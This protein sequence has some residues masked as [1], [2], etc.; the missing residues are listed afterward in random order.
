[1][2][3]VVLFGPPAVGKMTVGREL[4]RL[5]PYRLFHNHATIEPLLDVFAWGEPAF[6]LLREEFRRRI[7]EEAVATDLPGLVFTLVWGLEVA[8]D[9][10]YVE[11]LVEPVVAAGGRVDFAE[12]WSTQETRLAREGTPLRLE[13]KRS[14]RDVAWARAH[15]VESDA[16]HRL[17][18]SA[19]QPFPL[20][21]RFGHVRVDNDAL[22]PEDAAERVVDL[23]DLPRSSA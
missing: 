19:D 11:R 22:S 9:A 4:A 8:D 18:T 17:S 3:L 5:T 15:L 10:A 2:H 23:L 21:H 6:D 13:A 7:I 20:A 16:A 12:L 1:V 14:K